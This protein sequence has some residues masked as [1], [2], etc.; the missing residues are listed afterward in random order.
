VDLTK[1]T[2]NLFGSAIGGTNN[3]KVILPLDYVLA[4]NGPWA[5]AP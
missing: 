5:D 3:K 4:L 2:V 1:D